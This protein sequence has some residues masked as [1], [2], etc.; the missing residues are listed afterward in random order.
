[1]RGSVKR[2]NA[3]PSDLLVKLPGEAQPV[4]LADPQGGAIFRVVYRS[5]GIEVVVE[6]GGVKMNGKE[7]KPAPVPKLPS[8]NLKKPEIEIRKVPE[9]ST[10][11]WK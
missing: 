4:E 6:S 3:G 11:L 5:N 2:K 7:L 9:K 10:S 1:M 8:P